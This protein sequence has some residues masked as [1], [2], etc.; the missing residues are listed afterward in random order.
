MRHATPI[1]F[2]GFQLG[3]RGGSYQACLFERLVDNVG[4]RCIQVR[5][6]RLE[7]VPAADSHHDAGVH[8][9]V[10]EEALCKPATEIVGTHIAEIIVAGLV[11]GAFGSPFDNVSNAALSE[12]DE[13]ISIR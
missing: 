5:F 8:L 4:C 11:G 1:S 7:G 2:G 6:D 9:A 3:H 12:I 13:R 10:D